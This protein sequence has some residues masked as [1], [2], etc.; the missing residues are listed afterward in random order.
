MA[1]AVLLSLGPEAPGHPWPATEWRLLEAVCKEEL[2]DNSLELKAARFGVVCHSNTLPPQVRIAVEKLMAKC[3][4]RIIVATTTLVPDGSLP[5]LKGQAFF[6]FDDFLHDARPAAF[7]DHRING[8]Q[9][10]ASDLQIDGRL[11]MRFVFGVKNSLRRHLVTGLQAGLL[12]GDPVLNEKY[13]VAA[14]KQTVT[15]LHNDPHG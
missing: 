11:L 7:A 2:G 3:T 13:A 12:A 6:E 15:K 10:G 8:H 9:I 1:E 4:P 14:L 5:A